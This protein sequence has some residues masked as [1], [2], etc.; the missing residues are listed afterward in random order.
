MPHQTTWEKDGILWEFYEGVSFEEFETANNDFYADARSDA[1]KYQIVDGTKIECINMSAHES[2]ICAATDATA[3]RS[4]NGLKVALV[5]V[6]DEGAY[7][8]DEYIE[9]SKKINSSWKFNVFDNLESAREW[10]SS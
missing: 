6:P 8:V 4:I 10:V 3:S 2:H 1:C 5:G 7:L 9:M